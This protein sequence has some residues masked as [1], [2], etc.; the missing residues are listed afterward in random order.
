MSADTPVEDACDGFSVGCM[1]LTVRPGPDGIWLLAFDGHET[2]CAIGR[3]GIS[4]AKREGDGASPAGTYA[5]REGFFRPDRVTPPETALKLTPLSKDDG[6]CD[7]PDDPSYNRSVKLPYAASHE[8][9]WR[10]DGLYDV[11]VVIGYNDD[12]VVAGKGSAIFMHIC[13]EDYGPTAGC[14]AVPLGDM[15]TLL[16]RLS[17]A[18]RI[19]FTG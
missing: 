6:W 2:R 10:E 5:L 19:T 13:R 1:D 8:E 14:V 15:L 11:V 12:P 7:A 16:P 3:S 18:T 4:A 9:M 17:A